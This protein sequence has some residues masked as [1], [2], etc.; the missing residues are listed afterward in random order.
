MFLCPESAT[1]GLQNLLTFPLHRHLQA[2]PLVV[3]VVDQIWEHK[4]QHYCGQH[5]R[6]PLTSCISVLLTLQMA[7]CCLQCYL[8]LLF[9]LQFI[10]NKD[11]RNQ[12]WCKPLRIFIQ[13]RYFSV[14]MCRV[15]QT[16]LPA[17]DFLLWR[18]AIF[19]CLLPFLFFWQ[20]FPLMPC[21]QVTYGLF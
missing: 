17:L 8:L 4:K 18:D 16:L 9:F 12:G 11:R 13:G 7:D 3:L 10:W 2:L 5:Q 19:R 15:E 20:L 14:L 6:R 21:V 1:W